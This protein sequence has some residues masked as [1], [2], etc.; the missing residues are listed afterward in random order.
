MRTAATVVTIADGVQD[1]VDR[2]LRMRSRPVVD[3]ERSVRA[4]AQ[5]DG[6]A[7]ARYDLAR[8]GRGFAD[9]RERPA[10]QGFELGEVWLDQRDA[11]AY[12]GR[13]GFGAR[14][15]RHACSRRD[16]GREARVEIDRR[17]WRPRA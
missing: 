13:E 4:E 16:T 17:T 8:G 14:I 7:S 15:D 1:V 9:G 10:D 11:P 12:R 3:E 5:Q 2:R 6:V